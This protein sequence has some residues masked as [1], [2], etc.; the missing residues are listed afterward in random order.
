VP[1][2]TAGGALM[3]NPFVRVDHSAEALRPQAGVLPDSSSSEDGRV[4]RKVA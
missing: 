3:T 4:T 2:E 1:I